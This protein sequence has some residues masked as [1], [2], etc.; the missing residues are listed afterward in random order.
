MVY[1]DRNGK[2]VREST[3]TNDWQEAQRK[4]RERL[5]ASPTFAVGLRNVAESPDR[6]AQTRVESIK[7]FLNRL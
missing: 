4:L 2:R 5:Q 1:R 3:N 6:R 7:H